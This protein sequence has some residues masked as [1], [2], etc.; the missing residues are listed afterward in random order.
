MLVQNA[1]THLDVAKGGTMTTEAFSHSAAFHVDRMRYVLATIKKCDHQKE[2]ELLFFDFGQIATLVREDPNL[3]P[4]LKEN[5]LMNLRPILES[6]EIFSIQGDK[7]RV[8]RPTL[9]LELEAWGL[10]KT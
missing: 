6:L 2:D 9:E 4:L 1:E 8:L 3:T 10:S 7:I 5:I